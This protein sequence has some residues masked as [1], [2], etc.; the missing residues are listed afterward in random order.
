MLLLFQRGA[1]PDTAAISGAVSAIEA[2]SI[3]HM[4][5][6]SDST[7]Q[8]WLE[9]VIDGLTFDIAD[10]AP[11]PSAKMPEFKH[12][13]DVTDQIAAPDL[14]AIRIVPGPHLNGGT[15]LLPI[16][17]GL[18]SLGCLIGQRLPG[19]VAY[20]WPPALALTSPE[21]FRAHAGAWAKGGPFPSLVLASFSEASDQGLQSSGLSVFTG[22]ELRLEP[23]LTADPNE[24]K[25]LGGRLIAHLV[26]HG[27]VDEAEQFTGPDGHPLQLEP[28]KNGKF[29]RAWRG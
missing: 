16:L 28:S 11:G 26:M 27:R 15:Y 21:F 6:T 4:P 10:L 14:E 25:L 19:L 8:G 1:R 9:V 7:E 5:G 22:Q 13:S 23:E 20:S 17:R 2:A 3:S 24:A 29:V 12:R 18:L